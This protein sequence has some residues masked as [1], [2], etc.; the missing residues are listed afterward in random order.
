ME[1]DCMKKFFA[2]LTMVA[3]ITPFSIGCGDKK[4][5]TKKTT[6][7]TPEG[8]TKTTTTDTTKDR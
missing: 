3:L 2:M 7:T 6:T 5:D 4:V 8:G 1:I